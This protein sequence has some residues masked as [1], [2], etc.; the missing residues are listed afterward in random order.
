MLNSTFIAVH[1]R[2]GRYAEDDHGE[3]FHCSS[4]GLVLPS[5]TYQRSYIGVD[6]KSYT[7]L[8]HRSHFEAEGAVTTVD[9]MHGRSGGVAAAAICLPKVVTRLQAGLSFF[10]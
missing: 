3:Y 9:D 7:Y 10:C 8:V 5:S 1:L 4:H 6:S 2:T